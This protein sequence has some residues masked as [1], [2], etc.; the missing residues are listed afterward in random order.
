M[1]EK[2]AEV[3]RERAERMR[4]TRKVHGRLRTTIEL[5][6][7]ASSRGRWRQGMAEVFGGG[8]SNEWSLGAVLGKDGGR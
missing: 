2:K 5:L 8:A 7:L 4:A 1:K 3:R 6:A